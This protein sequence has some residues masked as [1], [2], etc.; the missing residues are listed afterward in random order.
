MTRYNEPDWRES[1]V[2]RQVDAEIFF[3]TAGKNGLRYAV[4]VATAK[5]VCRDCPVR[6]QCLEWALEH[7]E[8]GIAGGL[9][10]DERAELRR[11]TGTRAERQPGGPPP[12]SR[13]ET[14][15]AVVDAPRR[16]ASTAE[17]VDRFG[18][19]ERSVQRLAAQLRKELAEDAAS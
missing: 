3:P 18:V 14:T 1:A 4:E 8:Y 15:L 11:K 17:V 7:L 5:R 10:E 2:C 12:R 19:S 16:G 13:G 6:F 9:T